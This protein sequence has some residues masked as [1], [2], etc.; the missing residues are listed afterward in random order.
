MNRRDQLFEHAYE[1]GIK[2]INSRTEADRNKIAI[3]L[4]NPTL[5]DLESA[6][7]TAQKDMFKLIVLHTIKTWPE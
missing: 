1:L 2:V 6:L 7:E 4:L 5:D 3:H